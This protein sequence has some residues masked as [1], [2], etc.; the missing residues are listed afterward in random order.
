VD[1]RLREIGARLREEEARFLDYRQIEE[2]SRE[3][4]FPTSERT[5]RFYVTEGVLPAP[6]RRGGRTPVYEEGWILNVLLAVHVMK[7]RLGRSLAEV[8]AVLNRLAEDPTALADKVSVLYEDY[9]RGDTLPA[10]AAQRLVD[11]FFARLTGAGGRPPEQPSEVSILD[12]ARDLEVGTTMQ[13]PKS[14]AEEAPASPEPDA[15][16]GAGGDAPA[17]ADLAAPAGG[18]AATEA[19]AAEPREAP[20]AVTP[21]TLPEG[22][23]LVDKAKALE[24]L[25]IAR[26]DEAMATIRRVP[27]PLEQQ[28]YP[29][30]PRDRIHLKRTRA[31]EVIELMKRHRIYERE[32]LEALPLDEIS[33]YRVFTRSIFGKKDVRVVVAA[34]CV[35]PLEDFIRNKCSTRKAGARDLARAIQ[36]LSPQEGAFYYLGVLSTT[37]WEAGLER[38]IPA[39][40]NVLLALVENRGGTEWAVRRHRDERWAG[41]DRLFDP[42]SEREKI[43]RVRRALETHPDLTLRGGHVIV[44]NL[45][46]DLGVPEPVLAAAI[47]EVLARDDELSLLEVGGKEILKRRRI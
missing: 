18:S 9:V 3:L 46:E 24:E 41:L 33:E 39:T 8:R 22:A 38:H 30:G 17:A 40:P 6:A 5:L 1:D 25:L 34:C 4:G 13:D 47:R 19:A 12:L 2:K 28:L 36:A 29:A 45:K 15:Q 7:T 35:S 27:H 37:G 43:E 23:I 42:E 20:R 26:F 14:P 21:E 32:L 16:G 44:K 11:A 10:G 31:D